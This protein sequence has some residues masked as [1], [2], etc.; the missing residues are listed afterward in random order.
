[1]PLTRH[2]SLPTRIAALDTVLSNLRWTWHAPSR[3]LLERIDS[4][5]FAEA[6]GNPVLFRQRVSAARFR[7]LADDPSF[8]GELDRVAADLFAYLSGRDTWWQANHRGR[9]QGGIAYFSAEFG[10]HEGLPIYSG[11]LGVL[12]GDHIKSASDL[13][14]PLVAIGLFYRDGYFRQ[15]I[16]GVEQVEH[17][18]AHSPQELGLRRAVGAGGQPLDVMIP[19]GNRHIRAEVYLAEVGRVPLYLLDTDVV[20]NLDEDRW[21]T[22]RLYG[23]DS[24]TRIAQEVVLGIGGVRAL[25][26]AGHRP[27]VFHMNEGHTAFVVLERLREEVQRGLSPDR[28][29]EVIRTSTVFTTHTPVPAGHDRFDSQLIDDV[30]GR[31]RQQIDVSPSELMDLGRVRRMGAEDFCMTVLA[32]RASRCTNGVSRKHGEVSRVMWA[33]MHPGVPVEEVPIGHVTNGVHAASWM[34]VEVEGMLD[35]HLGTAWRGRLTQSEPMEE[36]DKIPDEAVWAAHRAGKERLLAVI[37]EHSGVRFPKDALLIGFARRFAPYKRGDLIFSDPEAAKALLRDPERPVC[38]VYAGK[39]HPKDRPGKD[40]IARVLTQVRS[41]ELHERVAFL[42][43]Y[44]I[45]LGRL[46]VQGADLWLNNPRR[47]HEASGTSGQKVAL[48]GGLNASTLDGWWIEAWDAE[49]RCGFAIGGLELESNESM[50]R[51]DRDALYR[52]LRE[53]VVPTWY[54]RD[55]HGLPRGW[56]RRMKRSIAVCLPRFNTHRMVADY[57]KQAYLGGR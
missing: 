53:E 44:D 9:L 38:L 39:S 12:A 41:Q 13:G 11:G 54:D 34:S 52:A 51:E 29:L 31:F 21:L 17:Y 4:D 7:A 3:A 23:G 45:G 55:E 26:A 2:V 20:G 19:F 37:E 40:I 36:V 1:M 46:L 48:N 47:P 5:A 14:I 56:I 33:D 25:R 22:R 27:D 16:E 57:V 32:L 6:R 10:I 50:D 8:V 24:R 42:E 43:D 15:S 49:P 18:N 35:E 30:L 28:A